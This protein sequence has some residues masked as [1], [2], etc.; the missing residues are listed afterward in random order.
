QGAV[1]E[2]FNLA[3]LYELP[4]IFIIENNQYAMGTA[5]ERAFAETFFV[6]HALANRLEAA[7]VNGMDVFAVCKAIQ[8]HAEKA[9]A[10]QP[11]LL[12]IRTYRYRGHSMSDPGK[13]R[14]KEELERK[15]KEDPI[16]RLKSYILEHGM[17]DNEALDQIDEEVKDVVMK[18]VEFAENSPFPPLES[19][20]EDVYVQEDYPFLA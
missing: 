16:I 8:D 10:F 12:E 19:I 6:K 18:S 1:H 9:R 2:A 17:A 3:G 11:C 13:Y 7:M 14:T 5:T 20:Y 15:K 4:V